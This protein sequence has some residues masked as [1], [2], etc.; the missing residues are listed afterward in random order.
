MNA[1]YG[2]IFSL[3][4]IVLGYKIIDISYKIIKYKK[5]SD[6]IEK[7]NGFLDS[8]LFRILITVF[9]GAAWAVS[10]FKT[11]N[12]LVSLVVGFLISLGIIMAY[13]D[14]KIRII[15]NELV[16]TMIV[17]GILFQTINFGP[18]AL[19]GAFVSMIAMMFVFTAVAGFVG[20]GKV[21]AGDVKLAGAMGI[22]LGYPLIIIAIGTMS[23]VLLIFILA[24]MILK[25]IYL[26]TMLPMAPFMIIGFIMGLMYLSLNNI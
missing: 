14:I 16:L 23:V 15:P 1:L 21:G 18:K 22:A 11:D 5:G 8:M 25:K 17:V 4:G 9:N 26:S 7:N 10:T 20:F 24:G 6:D 19:I 3:I 2:I 12:L 13:I